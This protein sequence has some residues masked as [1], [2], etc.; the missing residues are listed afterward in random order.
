MCSPEV[1]YIC[2]FQFRLTLSD[3]DALQLMY[4]ELYRQGV[5]MNEDFDIDPS[6][7]SSVPGRSECP[8]LNMLIWLE[9][10]CTLLRLM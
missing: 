6:V 9:V 3:E 5:F 1:T 8:T 2:L 10:E 7:E 4:Q